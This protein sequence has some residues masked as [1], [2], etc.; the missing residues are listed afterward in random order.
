[1][2]RPD[3]NIYLLITKYSEGDIAEEEYHVLKAWMEEDADNKKIFSEYLIFLKNARRV[4]F[5]DRV[6]N[7]IAWGVIQSQLRKR[8]SFNI[9]L[10]LRYAAV[11]L[12][13]VTL[14]VSYLKLNQKN[15]M[16]SKIADNS[17]IQPGKPK[18]IL[19][20]GDGRI[21]NLEEIG[22]SAAILAAGTKIQ[23]R[24]EVVDYRNAKPETEMMNTIRIPRGGE[25][26]L[27]LSDGTRVWLNSD[28]ELTF[29][30]RF[31]GKTREISLKGEAYLEVAKNKNFP[32]VVDVKGISVTVL[33][34][35]F[36]IKAYDKIETTLVE[37]KVSIHTDA[38]QDV[39]LTPNEQ[40]VVSED[41]SKV[42][43][44]HVDTRLFTAWK[45][46]VFAFRSMTLEEIMRTFE[47]WYDVKVT[48]ES[49]DLRNRR[50]TGNLKRYEDITPHLDM[51]GMTTDVDFKISGN[52][53]V[54]VK[55]K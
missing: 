38:S 20:L 23:K 44:K 30:M 35:S 15:A 43:V 46:G 18:A 10:Y 24:D 55:K 26:H 50:F 33:G 34:T 52:K 19:E 7:E 31:S 1:M 13:M 45:D 14:T 32:F 51:I 28:S 53:I 4:R 17:S 37:G 11:F 29:P 22:D 27:V 48:F 36:N 39:V 54:V 6:D 42:I 25:Y 49:D 12:M 9:K 2:V 41:H 16:E 3:S 21:V 47:R 8:K 40:G 5:S